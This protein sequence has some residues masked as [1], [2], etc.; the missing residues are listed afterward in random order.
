MKPN[1]ITIMVIEQTACLAT[2]R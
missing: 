1:E 2:L